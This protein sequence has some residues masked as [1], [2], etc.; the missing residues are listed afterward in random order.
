MEKYV[1]S[2]AEEISMNQ[3]GL[4]RENFGGYVLAAA[5]VLVEY[6]AVST[7]YPSIATPLA[8]VTL[9]GIILFYFKRGSQNT[10][11]IRQK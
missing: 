10:G 2:S 3:L 9:M 8:M 1:G 7:F 6:A 5:V 4:F 11:S